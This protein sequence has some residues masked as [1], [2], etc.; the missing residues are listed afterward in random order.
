[1]NVTPMTTANE[2]PGRSNGISRLMSALCNILLILMFC[3][4]SMIASAVTAREAPSQV[5]QP[6]QVKVVVVTM[7]EVGADEGDRAGEFQLW[8]ARRNLS[9]VYPFLG[10]RDLH[11]DPDSG[12]L[13]L[14][15]G[16]GTARSTAA[17]MALGMDPRFDLTQAYWVVTGIAGFD[18]EDAS[19]GSAAWAEYLV[20]GDL[21]I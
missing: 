13:V 17:V 15:T 9:K 14:V 20:D 19:I 16:I 12:L 11:F 5:D 1:M 4:V 6:V 8:K 7:F 2:V 21:S 18:P 3:S 10:Y